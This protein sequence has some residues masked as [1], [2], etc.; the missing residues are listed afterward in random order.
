MRQ[1]Y[2]IPIHYLAE[3]CGYEVI[4]AKKHADCNSDI[5]WI[6]KKK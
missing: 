5:I 3:K 1:S 2:S 6:L 4:E